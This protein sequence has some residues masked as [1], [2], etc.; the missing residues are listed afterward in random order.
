[1]NCKCKEP[2][3]CCQDCERE[4][5]APVMPRCDI[6]LTDGTYTNATVVVEDGC[7][8]SV[9]KGR[10]PQ[11]TPDICCDGGTMS[12]ATP[13]RGLKGDK[14]DKGQNAT[15][16]IGAVHQLPPGEKS[17]VVNTGTDTNAVLDFYI[18]QGP[19]GDTGLNA[20]GVTSDDGGISIEQGSI[21]GLPVTWPP[22][23]LLNG[24]IDDKDASISVSNPDS[25]T[26]AVTIN[27][28]LSPMV[29]RIS[30]ETIRRIQDVIAPINDRI[31]QLENRIS[32]LENQ[33]NRLLR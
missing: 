25:Q 3:D 1:M 24:T 17:R 32:Q 13:E 18:A 16:N 8:T 23:M 22:V 4:A 33:P 31:N 26:G 21:T 11:Y 7:I 5:P 28:T 27:V 19:K 20:S 12:G 15:I 14:G 6:A 10:A 29:N 30:D 2:L 9:A